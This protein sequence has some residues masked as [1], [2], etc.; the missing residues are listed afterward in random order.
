M[1]VRSSTIRA[2]P[3]TV[4]PV[5]QLVTSSSAPSLKESVMVEVA[6]N[7]SD[8]LRVAMVEEAFTKIPETVEVGV[9]VLGKARCQ[10]P[11]APSPPKS[12]LP[13]V[14]FPDE[15][16]SSAVQLLNVFTVSAP[17][18]VTAPFNL[19]VPKT[20]SVVEGA[21]VPMPTRPSLALTTRVAVSMTKEWAIVE[22]AVVDRTFKMS[23]A[24]EVAL[25]CADLKSEN[26]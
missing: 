7:D 23:V 10:D 12:S 5:P 24:V 15:S 8:T 2:P 20:P 1:H 21:A 16:A 14:M 4:N 22:E 6:D 9:K 13:Q 26:T 18:T 3:D 11:G 19:V 25:T 17:A